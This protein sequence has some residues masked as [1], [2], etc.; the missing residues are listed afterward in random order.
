MGCAETLKSDPHWAAFIDFVKANG[1][2]VHADIPL[3]IFTEIKD[4]VSKSRGRGGGGGGGFNR[5][6][7]TGRGIGPVG[8]GYDGSS[9]QY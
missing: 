4:V 9:G 7:P 6:G 3:H 2:F 8:G 5:N 1:A